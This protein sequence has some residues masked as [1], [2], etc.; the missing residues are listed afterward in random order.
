MAHLKY[1]GATFSEGE[2]TLL[3]IVFDYDGQEIHWFPKWKDVVD[4]VR[5]SYI[6]EECCNNGQLS[7]L[8]ES[9][10]KDLTQTTPLTTPI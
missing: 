5:M 8:F 7:L 1:L 3:Y 6:T 9:C 4:I 10:L 2:K